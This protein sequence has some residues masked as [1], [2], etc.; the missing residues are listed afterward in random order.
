MKNLAYYIGFLVLVAL[1]FFGVRSLFVHNKKTVQTLKTTISQTLTDLSASDTKVIQTTQGPV[2]GDEARREVRITIGRSERKVEVVQGYQNTV[3]NS[4][5]FYNNQSAYDI[6]LRSIAR[7]GYSISRKANPMD[8][9]GVCSSGQTFI[10]EVVDSGETKL[11]QRLWGASCSASLGTF[12]GNGPAIRNLFQQQIPNYSTI[13][14]NAR[15]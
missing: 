4:Q 7:L 14:S 2:V 8:E 1:L 15:I 9:R 11:D 5:S 10:Y 12:K 3:I 13:V 6:F